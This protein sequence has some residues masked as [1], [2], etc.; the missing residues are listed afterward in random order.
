M[1]TSV[2]VIAGKSQKKHLVYKE[3]GYARLAW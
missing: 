1:G 3:N 2:S